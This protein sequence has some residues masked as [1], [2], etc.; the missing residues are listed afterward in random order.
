MTAF[1]R[2][3]YHSRGLKSDGKD[4]KSGFKLSRVPKDVEALEVTQMIM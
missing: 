4:G 1:G 2:G 3:R